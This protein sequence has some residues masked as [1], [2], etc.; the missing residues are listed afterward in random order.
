[1]MHFQN[2]TDNDILSFLLLIFFIIIINNMINLI[3]VLKISGNSE[4]I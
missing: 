3:I 2:V 4:C 1:M